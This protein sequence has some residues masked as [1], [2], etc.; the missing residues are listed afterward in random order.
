MPWQTAARAV[1]NDDLSPVEKTAQDLI[2]FSAFKDLLDRK[3]ALFK[4]S[5]ATKDDIRDFK[6]IIK[7]QKSKIDA[8]ESR[9]VLMERYI[10]TLEV[11]RINRNNTKGVC[12]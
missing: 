12:A 10:N 6:R 9:T 3:V 11:L 4:D 7:D 1:K 5:L 8:P 2:T